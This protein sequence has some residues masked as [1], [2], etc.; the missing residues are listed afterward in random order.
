MRKL[1]LIAALSVAGVAA[2]LGAATAT[3]A[4]QPHRHA[5][6]TG[7]IIGKTE[8]YSSPSNTSIVVQTLHNGQHVEV[9][10]FRHGQVLHGNSYWFF[11]QHL[12]VRGY[13]HRHS[14]HVEGHVPHC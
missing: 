5:A 6:G 14:I 3:A 13:V 10:C 9:L 11:I 12:G 8:S 2:M 1:V 4:A 7:I